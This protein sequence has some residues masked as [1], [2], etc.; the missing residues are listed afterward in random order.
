VTSHGAFWRKRA[1]L[2]NK[3]VKRRGVYVGE[4]LYDKDFVMGN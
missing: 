1:R 3:G 4:A 2:V